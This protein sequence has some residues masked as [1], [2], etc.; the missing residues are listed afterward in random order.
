MDTVISGSSAT[1]LN[2]AHESI[3]QRAEGRAL[4][5]VLL[6]LQ[7]E[8][9]QP[10]LTGGHPHV[11]NA[12]LELLGP[13]GRTGIKRPHQP[14]VL[15]EPLMTSAFRNALLDQTML[16]AEYQFDQIAC[17]TKF[18]ESKEWQDF[19]KVT[20]SIYTD[21]LQEKSTS[22]RKQAGKRVDSTSTDAGEAM[23]SLAA[24]HGLK[25][26][27]NRRS[28]EDGAL[29]RE[30]GFVYLN[31]PVDPSTTE[32][33]GA[34]SWMVIHLQ[35][36]ILPPP[37]RRELWTKCL[38]KNDLVFAA[39]ECSKTI[40]LRARE[41][42]LKDPSVTSVS[43]VIKAD[44]FRVAMA[45]FSHL[46]NVEGA[47][48]ISTEMVEASALSLLCQRSERLLNLSYTY[49]G[50]HDALY[51][52]LAVALTFAMTDGIDTLEDLSNNE[53]SNDTDAAN[54][55]TEIDF[56]NIR[57]S[58]NVA[59]LQSLITNFAPSAVT[60]ARSSRSVA[61]SAYDILNTKDPELCSHIRAMCGT[62]YDNN[63]ST[64]AGWDLFRVW[65]E[66]VFVG[67]LRGATV[68]FIWDQ[69]FL[70]EGGWAVNLP[71][72]LV[73]VAL[74][75]RPTILLAATGA[76]LRR[77]VEVVGKRLLTRDVQRAYQTRTRSGRK[78]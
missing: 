67:H 25:L 74:L 71:P 51:V 5:N 17:S 14:F 44:V 53:S 7:A 30:R 8:A 43:R 20:Q 52:P 15:R 60:G 41:L 37:L 39:K 54:R 64:T 50:S 18:W 59:L 4:L 61:A 29:A 12:A 2:G 58:E 34:P 62:S 1:W 63:G 31:P 48:D 46:G 45:A 26:C 47:T 6:T 11:E 56:M 76:E 21:H 73:D 70:G 36:R 69:L 68:L 13:H 65:T 3:S 55:N 28:A 27:G 19:S 16:Q 35:G 77:L 24:G 75:L 22:E 32:T 66:D 10:L 33:S 38:L 23:I 72:F 40:A 49:S 9:V 42:H 57:D 78:A